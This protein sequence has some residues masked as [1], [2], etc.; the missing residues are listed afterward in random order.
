M[1]YASLH[2]PAKA[3]HAFC[4]C[5]GPRS[6]CNETRHTG[7]GFRGLWFR[8]LG[9]WGLGFRFKGLGFRAFQEAACPT[10]AC[11]ACRCP[12]QSF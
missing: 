11:S 4:S 1:Q 10:P 12:W 8:G 6:R 5:N 2:K 3:E 7:L 9:F